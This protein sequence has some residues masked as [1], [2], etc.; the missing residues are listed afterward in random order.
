MRNLLLVSCILVL[1]ACTTVDVRKAPDFTCSQNILLGKSAGPAAGESSTLQFMESDRE[2]VATMTCSNISD[3][4]TVRWEWYDPKGTLY[5]SSGD[6]ILSTPAGSYSP[7]AR[8]SHRL[9]VQ[10]DKAAELDGTW[11][12]RAVVDG[13]INASRSFILARLPD[14]MEQVRAYPS[15]TADPKRYALVIGIENYA[16]T[17]AARFATRDAEVM[18]ELFVRRFG[19][20]EQNVITLLNEKATLGALRNQ[21][22]NKLHALPE[23]AVLYV[24][25]SGHGAPM[26]PRGGERTATPYLLPYDGSP[27][28]LENTGYSL[29]EFYTALDRL[30]ASQVFVLLDS[31][32][33]GTTGRASNEKVALAS[34]VKAVELY[35]KDPAIASRK[36]VSITSSQND[37]ISN[38]SERD[39]LGL[40][41]SQMVKSLIDA[42]SPLRRQT[43]VSVGD[44]F[45]QLKKNVQGESLRVFGLSRKQTPTIQ[46]DRT[47]RDS[48]LLIGE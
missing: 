19:V 16:E 3:S 2:I 37:Q 6:S 41:T 27:L 7:G 28:N 4:H 8:I 11:Q 43:M 10:G 29:A 23:N 38:S 13:D 35:V 1:S 47:G 18:R 39:K 40:F 14:L 33:S 24:Y 34:N 15:Q 45:G 12:V 30:P 36:V 26:P 20:P 22:S 32:F 17:P 31:C 48:I 42:N 21:L 44:L 25:Y 9:T 46:P 5:Y